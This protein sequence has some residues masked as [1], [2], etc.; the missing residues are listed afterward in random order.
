MR[1]SWIAH[2]RCMSNEV[3]SC[4]VLEVSD[5]I[6]T[7]LLTKAGVFMFYIGIDIAKHNHEALA[8]HEV[9]RKSHREYLIRAL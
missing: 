7:N 2:R 1:M 9:H 6:C 4:K 3:V 8:V 5:F